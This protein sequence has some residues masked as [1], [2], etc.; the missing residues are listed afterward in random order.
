MSR[1]TERY[2]LLIIGPP[3][4]GK[5]TVGQEI[6]KLTDFRLFH[7]HESIETAINL[8]SYGSKEFNSI[9]Q[10]IRQLVFDTVR[11]S[12]VIRGFIFTLVCAYNMKADINEINNITNQFADSGWIPCIAELYSPLDIR[13]KRNHTS[14]RIN[15][16]ESKRD[17]EASDKRLLISHDKFITYSGKNVFDIKNF[18]SIDNSQ[19][20]ASD[21]AVK[22]IESFKF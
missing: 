18:I 8:F 6:C 16:K 2:F 4:V 17:L 7:N 3:A 5:M 1:S 15:T 13:L 21:T 11:K 19:L 14:N 9:N 20:N 12:E 10:G 22:I